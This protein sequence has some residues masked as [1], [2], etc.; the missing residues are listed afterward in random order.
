MEELSEL[1]FPTFLQEHR[2]A[3]VDFFAPWCGP[4]RAIGPTIEALAE[5]FSG[6]AGIAKCNVDGADFL[7]QKYGVSSIP[8]LIFF[9]D[10]EVA[11]TLIGSHT[12]EELSKIL[13][14]LLS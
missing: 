13:N 5:E 3:L 14:R 10:G 8:T 12:K 7:A 6:R 4:C 11:E 9:R 2:V 1:T